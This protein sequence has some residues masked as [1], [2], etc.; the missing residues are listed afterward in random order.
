LRSGS[1]AYPLTPD[2]DVAAIRREDSLRS[3]LSLEL[4]D[5][6]S[7]EELENPPTRPRDSDLLP[8]RH[9][10]ARCN[11]WCESPDCRP[12]YSLKDIC[13]TCLLNEKDGGD[14]RYRPLKRAL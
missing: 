11:H 7:D 6:V 14:R 5:E 4:W 13:L 1:P 3:D 10:H 8:V 9:F 12:M 2:E